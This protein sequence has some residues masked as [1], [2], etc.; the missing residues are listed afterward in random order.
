MNNL[1]HALSLSILLVGF[2]PTAFAADNEPSMVWGQIPREY[3]TMSSF[4]ADTNA[5][6]VVLF[7]FGKVSF[8]DNYD[9]LFTRHTRLK[10][11]NKGDSTGP[12]RTFR[13]MRP[14]ELNE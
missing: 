10:I 5:T 3:L 8:D 11:L 9:I 1:A 13:T 4:P 2:M 6:V 12:P 14:K 7:D